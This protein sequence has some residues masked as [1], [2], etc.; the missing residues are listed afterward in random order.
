MEAAE[1]MTILTRHKLRN[2]ALLAMIVPVA[3]KDASD[4]ASEMMLREER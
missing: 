2:Q 1:R 3:P 4:I